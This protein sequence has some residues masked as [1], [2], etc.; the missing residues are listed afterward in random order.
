MPEP[1]KRTGVHSGINKARLQRDERVGWRMFGAGLTVAS[2]VMA[3]AVLGWGVDW[4]M[5]NPPKWGVLVGAVL[6]I[7]VAMYTLI[8]T[9]YKLNTEM[10]RAAARDRAEDEISGRAAERRREQEALKRAE[11]LEDRDS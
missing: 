5:G 6:G 8:R 10:D 3:G 11:E 9:A 7:V 2:E 4:L 1:A